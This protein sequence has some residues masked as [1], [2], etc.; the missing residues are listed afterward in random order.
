MLSAYFTQAVLITVYI[1]SLLS[2]R[3]DWLSDRKSTVS[4]IGRTLLAVQ[5]STPSFLN[6]SIVFSIAMLSASLVSFANHDVL[7]LSTLAIMLLM[8]FGSVLPVTLLQLAASDTLRRHRGRLLSWILMAALMIVLLIT[9]LILNIT[10]ITTEDKDIK[11]VNWETFCLG[12]GNVYNFFWFSLGLAGLLILGIVCFVI[13]SFSASLQRQSAASWSRRVWWITLVT[14][15]IAMWLCLG[16]FVLLQMQR[17]DMAGKDNKDTKW[18]FGQILAVATWVPVIIEFVYIW[19][20]TPVKALSG[21]LMDPYEVKEVLKKN[22][23]FG[24][25]RRRQTV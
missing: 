19:W 15:F 1:P 21:Q 5:H 14:A 22:E 24:S 8:P 2:V 13:G 25:L 4:L 11:Q 16:W 17:N 7:T 10:N 23:G 3:F 20:E 9:A 6:A 12:R 18:S